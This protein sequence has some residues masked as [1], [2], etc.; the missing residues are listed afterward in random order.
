MTNV[1]VYANRLGKE[2]FITSFQTEDMPN[3]HAKDMIVLDT[4]INGNKMDSVYDS[5]VYVVQDAMY[6]FVHN[7][8]N[9]F[10]KVYEW[11]F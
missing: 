7:E 3:L 1:N 8:L 6:D 10:V 11:E 2:K 9:L 4:D 5:E